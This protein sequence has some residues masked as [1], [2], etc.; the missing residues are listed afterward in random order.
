MLLSLNEQRR[1]G[2]ES[3]ACEQCLGIADKPFTGPID[4]NI[5]FHVAFL[6]ASDD[7][8]VGPGKD[9]AVAAEQIL[10]VRLRPQVHELTLDREHFPVVEQVARTKAGAIDDHALG[11]PGNIVKR[12][13]PL[14]H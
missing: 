10:Q 7:H 12:P 14:A 13:E 2:K 4:G 6:G 11:Q 3:C 1:P 8:R 9:V 5:V